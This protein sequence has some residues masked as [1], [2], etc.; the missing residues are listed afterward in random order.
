MTKPVAITTRA[1]LERCTAA[2]D[3]LSAR[4]NTTELLLLRVGTLERENARLAAQL[5]AALGKANKFIATPLRT[6]DYYSGEYAAWNR[7]YESRHKP[8]DENGH[9]HKR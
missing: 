2:L 9:D 1:L 4:D 7:E 8:G 5:G 6:G 3:K